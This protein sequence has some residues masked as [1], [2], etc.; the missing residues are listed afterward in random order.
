MGTDEYIDF[1]KKKKK[2]VQ[3]NSEQSFLTVANCAALQLDS[4]VQTLRI[5]DR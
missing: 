1:G 3:E 2:V 5:L 4:L